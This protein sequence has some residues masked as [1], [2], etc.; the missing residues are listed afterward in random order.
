MAF[1]RLKLKPATGATLLRLIPIALQ[2][3]PLHIDRLLAP[4]RNLALAGDILVD[5]IPITLQMSTYA[6]AERAT[7]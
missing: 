5:V 6:A 2:P 3:A 1:E 4:L 7:Q